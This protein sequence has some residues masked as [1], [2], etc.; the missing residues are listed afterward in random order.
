MI[1]EIEWS[2][3]HQFSILVQ[4][5]VLG[6]VMGFSFELLSGFGRCKGRGWLF[7]A[8]ILYCVI[9]ALVSFFSSLVMT[10]GKL[11]PVMFAGLLLGGAIEHCTIGKTVSKQTSKFIGFI[12]CGSICLVAIIRQFLLKTVSIIK[13]DSKIEKNIKKRRKN[14]HFFQ[15]KA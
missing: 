4:S 2:G 5:G 14:P 15:K 7:L 9:S 6:L 10:D 1:H 3:M 11:H 8:D 12:R 13:I